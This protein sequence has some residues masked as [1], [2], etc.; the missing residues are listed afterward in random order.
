MLRLK[1]KKLIGEV[2]CIGF[3][4]RFPGGWVALDTEG[5][6]L[7]PYGERGVDRETAPAR[8]YGFSFCNADGE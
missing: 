3:P 8:P 2:E 1:V 4:M 5:T 7:D 6:G